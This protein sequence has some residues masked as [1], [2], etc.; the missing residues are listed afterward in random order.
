MRRVKLNHALEGTALGE[1]VYSPA[2]GLVLGAG[3]RLGRDELEK[4][5]RAGVAEI[6]V[7]D[8]WSAGITPQDAVSPGTRGRALVLLRSIWED[9][10]SRKGRFELPWGDLSKVAG[11][12]SDELTASKRKTVELVP[13]GDL[14][15]FPVLQAYNG[16]LLAAALVRAIGHGNRAVDIILGGFCRDLGMTALP[17]ELLFKRK[18]LTPEERAQVHK[19]PDLS[20]KFLD[21]QRA[22]AYT[23]VVIAQH[24]ERCD[25]S[26]YS[27]GLAEKDSHLYSKVMAI[28]DVYSAMVSPRPHRPA[29]SPS[30]A[31]EYLVS[32]AGFEFDHL[33]VQHFIRIAVPYPVGTLV[34][35]ST[36]EKAIV[37]DVENGL[38]GRPLVR[39]LTDRSGRALDGPRELDLSD[40]GQQSR[41]I[42]GSIESL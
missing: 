32:A 6:L 10:S 1:P 3:A 4:L 14:K 2:G 30:E 28:A 35:L 34:V 33:L 22:S 25:G 11:D 40:P 41:L 5:H 7:D 23:K 13:V 8:E 16:A 27:G 20:L 39:I 19:H 38:P 36:G 37:M 18:S 17:D 29:Y 26:G 42:A 12:L 21:G 24:H 31:A 15:D 9:A